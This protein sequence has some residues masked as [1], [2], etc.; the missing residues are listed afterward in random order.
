MR[1][2]ICDVIVVTHTCWVGIHIPQEVQK[3]IME[4]QITQLSNL[5]LDYKVVDLQVTKRF[6][7][8][9]QG[10]MASQKNLT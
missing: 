6:T 9:S 8:P 3:R 5:L 7:I 10:A 2:S 4:Q 1:A